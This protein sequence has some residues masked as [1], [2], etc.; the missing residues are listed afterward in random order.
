MEIKK[1][2]CGPFQANCYVI[3]DE[4]T[5]EAAVIDP[6]SFQ[7]KIQ[8]AIDGLD[9]KYI[10]LTHGHFDHILGVEK[11]QNATGA[12]LFI[13]SADEACLTNG[14]EN[15]INTFHSGRDISLKA[16][17]LLS[18]GDEIAFGSIKLKVMHTPGHSKG[19]VCFI[20][21][22]PR[23]IFSGDTIFCNTTGRTDLYGGDIKELERSLYKIGN[24]DGDYLI[25]P[26]HDENTTLDDE[27]KNYDFINKYKE[28]VI[29]GRLKDVLNYD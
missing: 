21:E 19:S 12:K 16:D 10:L 11:M 14:D 23:I 27:R 3:Y 17:K 2:P 6:G 7:E 13:H 18:D 24:L 4:N 1:I 25:L 29:D 28:A 22:N 26:G 8:K 5:K 9:V 20:S 15:L